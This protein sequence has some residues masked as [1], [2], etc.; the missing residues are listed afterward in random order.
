MVRKVISAGILVVLFL[1]VQV[2]IARADLIVNGVA[3]QII[4]HTPSGDLTASNSTGVVPPNWDFNPSPLSWSD[5]TGND[6]E[7]SQSSN[8]THSSSSLHLWGRGKASVSTGEA[9]PGSG[10]GLEFTPSADSIFH[11]SGS[12]L[13]D[14]FQSGYYVSGGLNFMGWSYNDLPWY[15][16]IYTTNPGDFNL[17]G[18]LDAGRTYSLGIGVYPSVQNSYWSGDR[19]SYSGD[20]QIDLLVGSE[21]ASYPVPEPTSMLFLVSTVIGLIGLSRKFKN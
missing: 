21:T 18:T 7:A 2:G 12:L 4:I 1:S 5:Q 20:W 15:Y 17:T 11:L 6:A 3:G 8:L 14:I 19:S 16:I 10:I 13:G 9:N